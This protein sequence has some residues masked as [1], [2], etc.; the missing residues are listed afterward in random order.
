M[1]VQQPFQKA[2][3]QERLA[4]MY[5]GPWKNEVGKARFK[6]PVSPPP[7]KGETERGRQRQGL[8]VAQRP[9][10]PVEGI[11]S[12]TSHLPQI[13]QLGDAKWYGLYWGLHKSRWH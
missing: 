2:R 3:I 4:G 12:V 5:Q 8:A 6:M 11:V 10:K 1:W 13:W 7:L 9:R